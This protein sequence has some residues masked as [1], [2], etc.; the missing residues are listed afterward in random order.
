MTFSRPCR[1]TLNGCCAASGKAGALVGALL[2]ATGT[3]RYGNGPVMLFCSAVSFLSF[4]LTW[5][6]VSS[7]LGDNAT[8]DNKKLAVPESRRL[9]DHEKKSSMTVVLSVPSLFDYYH[10][11]Y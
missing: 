5:F 8:L 2:F 6:F 3:A 4:V 1:A 9:M 7:L 11:E 10:D